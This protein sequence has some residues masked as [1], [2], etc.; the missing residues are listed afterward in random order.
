M[1]I[2][3]DQLNF[4]L[5]L[6]ERELYSLERFYEG[7]FNKISLAAAQAFTGEDSPGSLII[8]GPA[9]SG[10]SH[11]LKG[12]YLEN[13]ER[14][15]S[16]YVSALEL[17]SLEDE[18]IERAVKSLSNF[19]L[20]CIDDLDS[21]GDKKTFFDEVFHL[22]NNI[23][24]KGG[25]FAAAMRSSPAGAHF[26]PDYLSSRLLSGMVVTIKKPG[27][28]EKREIIKKI[29][30]DRQ[31]SLEPEGIDFI[32]ERS[33]RSVGDL[34][35]LMARLEANIPPGSGKLG[36]QFLRRVIRLNQG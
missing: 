36:L 21:A 9:G 2:K 10:K 7:E 24:Q 11:L 20:V 33:S 1:G 23:T 35:K 22:F 25:F 29:A 15:A 8:T 26:L 32:L 31:I 34:V 3:E 17:S 4:G 6:P 30:A 12:I 13:A 19:G 18:V 16:F 28:E 14:L 27:D 5:S